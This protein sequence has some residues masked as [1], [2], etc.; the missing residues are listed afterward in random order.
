MQSL[1]QSSNVELLSSLAGPKPA[2]ALMRRYGGLTAIARAPFE[3]LRQLKG[4]GP[5]KA[6]AIRS[7][8]LLAQ[9]LSRESYAESPVMNSAEQVAGLLRDESRL[10]SVEHFHV[11]CL[12]TRHRMISVEAVSR[13]LLDQVLVDAREVFGPA[14][15]RRAAAVI[16]SHNHPSGDPT[17][18]EADI[19][20]TRNLIRAG[21]MLRIEVL[22]HVILGT[23]T[24]DR[25]RDYVSLRELG[26]FS[27]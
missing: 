20:M 19:R 3:E 1:E 7:A 5:A 15:T 10:H 2:E 16:L 13:G 26:H 17:P 22:D 18:S 24:A 9:R 12:N 6:S 23:S 11:I 8:F 4:V 27:V 14:L 25:P 21:Q